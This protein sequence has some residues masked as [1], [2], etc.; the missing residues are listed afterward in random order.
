[1]PFYTRLFLTSL[2]SLHVRGGLYRFSVLATYGL[3]GRA[4]QCPLYILLYICIGNKTIVKYTLKSQTKLLFE[5]MIFHRIEP[6]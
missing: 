5:T 4:H 1:M 6:V 3:S 2:F